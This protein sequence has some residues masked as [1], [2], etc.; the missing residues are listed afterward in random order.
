[1]AFQCQGHLVGR[2]SAAVIGHFKPGQPPVD[3][4]DRNP[5][6][7]GIDRVFNQFLERGGRA[8][9]HFTGGNAVD[10]RFW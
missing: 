1:M 10:Q 6:G 2:H 3:Q 4:L 8:L 5:P 9:H 7:A